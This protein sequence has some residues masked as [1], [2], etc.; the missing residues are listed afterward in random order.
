MT[1]P[2]DPDI[3][4]AADYIARLGISPQAPNELAQ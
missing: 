2:T 3:L 4:T 1:R